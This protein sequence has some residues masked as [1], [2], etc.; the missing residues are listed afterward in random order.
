MR[1]LVEAVLARGGGKVG[2]TPVVAQASGVAYLRLGQI[3]DAVASFKESLELARK[4]LPKDDRRLPEY[5]YPVGVA[6]AYAR[7]D[8]AAAAY[9]AEAYEVASRIWGP[10]HP[11][12][13]RYQI[14]LAF[15]HG[16]LGQCGAAIA[17]AEHARAILLKGMPL[18]ASV[19]LQATE[20]IGTCEMML[21]QYEAAL[22]EHHKRLDALAKHGAENS[23]ETAGAL[24]DIGDVEVRQGKL[25]PAIADYSRAVTM[26]E[27]IVGIGDE[28]LTVPLTQRG[29]AEVDA[30]DHA[31][32]IADLERAL[33]LH[34]AAKT[35]AITVADAKLGLARALWPADKTRSHALAVE[36]RDVYRT[37][38][39]RAFGDKVREAET[40][41]AI[42]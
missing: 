31:K 15:R 20:I 41:L 27:T 4:L 23:V 33:A 17:E 11:N 28:R 21:H 42:H 16:A 35:P 5:I 40:W 30:N 32:A 34:A 39:P 3:D 26:M 13:V 18:H 1:P 12:A 2:L 37:G 29:I 9:H 14:H 7:R 19:N 8:A 38:D 25:A 24:V 6:L 10:D 22:R 36:A